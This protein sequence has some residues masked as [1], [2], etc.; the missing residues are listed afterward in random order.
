MSAEEDIKIIG[1]VAEEVTQPRLD[2]TRGSGLHAVPL[3]LSRA[4]DSTW[5]QLFVRNWDSPPAFTT[6]HRPG[7]AAVYGAKIVLNGTTMEEVEQVHRDTLRL[8]VEETNRQWRELKGHADAAEERRRAQHD[9]HTRN[10]Q[11]ISKRIT[12]D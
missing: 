1:V 12:F 9:E 8:V 11:D 2:G 4:A 5:A 6:L 7:I 3:R 10:V